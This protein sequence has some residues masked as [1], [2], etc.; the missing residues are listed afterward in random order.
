MNECSC[1][2]PRPRH[3]G[4]HPTVCQYCNLIIEAE[5]FGAERGCGNDIFK[6]KY[7]PHKNNKN[8]MVCDNCNVK[9]H[10]DLYEVIYGGFCPN[11]NVKRCN[12]CS[13]S[14]KE[15][16]GEY[17]SM[18]LMPYE[19]ESFDAEMS[20]IVIPHGV[21]ITS[22]I[23]KLSQRLGKHRIMSQDLRDKQ[24]EAE[25]FGADFVECKDESCDT[26]HCSTC[27]NCWDGIELSC[28]KC[29]DDW[30]GYSKL[31]DRELYGAE[32]ESFGAEYIGSKSDC[33]CGSCDE[34]QVWNYAKIVGGHDSGCEY[35]CGYCEDL[36]NKEDMVAIFTNHYNDDDGL[37]CITCHDKLKRGTFEAESFKDKSPMM[38]NLTIAAIGALALIIG[39]K[40]TR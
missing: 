10:N 39:R 26:G 31:L 5:S 15:M 20:N 3:A 19:A 18:G 27:G 1:E 17:Y 33:E 37:Y 2:T 4:V 34:C 22:K 7:K 40:V 29:G 11:C 35:R 8:Y 16:V 38:Q 30:S 25:S 23:E 21:D 14:I 12:K 24:F 6:H 28:S 32:A 36:G 13:A 9:L